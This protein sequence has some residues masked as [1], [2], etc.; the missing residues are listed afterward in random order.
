MLVKTHANILFLTCPNSPTGTIYACEEIETILDGFSGLVVI[1][2]AYVDFSDTPGW[3]GRLSAYPNLVILQTF[4]KYWGL[5]GCRVGMMY[6]DAGI[7]R[8]LAKI[9]MPYNVNTLSAERALAAVRDE[10]NV[11]KQADILLEQRARLATELAAF[12]FV[13]KVYPSQANFLWIEIDKSD[14]VR[15]FLEKKGIIVRDFSN[16]PQHL[17]MTVGTPG[18]NVKL[19]AVLSEYVP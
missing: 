17:R 1:D 13:R 19:L 2:E 4:S 3:A 10:D 11:R 14:R 9:K 7:I 15:T 18:E 8:T 12:P 5:A 16:H 6:A